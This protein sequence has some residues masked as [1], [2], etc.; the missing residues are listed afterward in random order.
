MVPGLVRQYGAP[1]NVYRQIYF[2][3]GIAGASTI[4]C[5]ISIKTSAPMTRTTY[6]QDVPQ[7]INATTA[8]GP[9]SSK[10]AAASFDLVNTTQLLKMGGRVFTLALDQRL[11]LPGLPSSLSGE[12]W[13]NIFNTLVSHPHTK[14]RSAQ[15][16]ARPYRMSCHPVD[17]TLYDHFAVHRGHLTFDEFFAHIGTWSAESFALG[18]EADRP[19]STVVYLL[20]NAPE[21]QAV[22]FAARSQHLTRWPVASLQ[23]TLVKPSPTGSAGKVAANIK[24]AI[25]D[26]HG[27]PDPMAGTI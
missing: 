15:D 12:D 4:G 19:M 20:D 18:T 9:T 21:S 2:G 1:D 22:A 7:L 17:Q 5:L 8:G 27:H 11:A 14:A 6:M 13:N 16:F 10:I 24:K 3:T 25:E 26:K 23:S